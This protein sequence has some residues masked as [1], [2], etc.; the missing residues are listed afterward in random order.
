[1]KKLAILIGFWAAAGFLSVACGDSEEP[2][3]L[4]RELGRVGRTEARQEP[5]NGRHGRP[6][7]AG[8]GAGAPR[9]ALRVAATGGSCLG[10]RHG[11]RRQGEGGMGE[12]GAEGG[13][14]AT[15]TAA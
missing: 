6:E 3:R 1:M 15:A 5:S 10:G 4:G 2:Q 9:A 8:G 14:A 7:P 11:R 13:W 12:G